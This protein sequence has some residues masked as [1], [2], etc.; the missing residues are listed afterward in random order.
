LFIAAISN[1]FLKEI[2]KSNIE[3]LDMKDFLKVILEEIKKYADNQRWPFP[4]AD[5]SRL[6]YELLSHDLIKT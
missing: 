6:L 1:D 5:I 3:N 2:Q 4:R